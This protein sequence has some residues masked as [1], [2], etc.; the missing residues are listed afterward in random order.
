MI[1]DKTESAMTADKDP[2]CWPY[3]LLLVIAIGLGAPIYE[4][5]RRMLEPSTGHWAAFALGVL[6]AMAVAFPVYFAAN[7]I[8]DRERNGKRDD[9]A[10]MLYRPA[11]FPLW[12]FIVAAIKNIRDFAE[13]LP[14]I[15]LGLVLFFVALAVGIQ[16]RRGAAW[17]WWI[18][19]PVGVLIGLVA[20]PTAGF[21]TWIIAPDQMHPGV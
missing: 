14:W 1:D 12:I 7:W 19:V 20:L 2:N 10:A 16:C 6:A 13:L 21:V 15:Y 3:L 9:L 11:I 8:V 18:A 17:S 4:E 5:V